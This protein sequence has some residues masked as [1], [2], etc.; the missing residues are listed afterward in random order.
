VAGGRRF[1]RRRRAR[2]W[3][4]WRRVLVAGALAGG[5]VV[6]VW[7]VFFSSVLNVTGA[8][9]RGTDL[10]TPAE[11]EEIAEV[12]LGVPLATANLMAVQ[13][14]VEALPEVAAA[15]VSRSWPHDI[16]IEITER[17]PVAVVSWEGSWRALDREGV[18]FRTFASRPE[19][20][21]GVTMR[22]DT[23]SEALAEVAA[24]V[25]GLPDDLAARV[26][27]VDVT[28]IDGITLWLRRGAEV[29][30]G[31]AEQPEEKAAVLRLLLERPARVY[32]VSAPG[33][34]TLRG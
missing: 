9:V 12:P 14:R 24:V 16:R 33:R 15:E 10:L 27:S 13:A 25:D 19:G 5:L 11:V 1:Q 17:E 18:L 6:G 20:L 30:W 31:S 21:L 2:R 7:L 34:P 29:R 23:P 26:R 22:S 4:A 28:S 3:L 32:D 8:E